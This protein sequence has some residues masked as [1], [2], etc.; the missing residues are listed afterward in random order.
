MPLLEVH[1][2]DGLAQPPQA[3]G[4]HAQVAHFLRHAAALDGRRHGA[5]REDRAGRADHAVE[6][7]LDDVIDVAVDLFADELHH[8]AFVATGDRI[9][10]DEALGQPDDADLEAARE[11][12]P[13]ARC[14]A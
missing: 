5:E 13:R 10:I 14:R 12:R 11:L 4:G 3:L 1:F 2:D 8:L 7:R 6:T 9:G